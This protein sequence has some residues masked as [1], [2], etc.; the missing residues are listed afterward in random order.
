[1]SS[2][3][4]QELVPGRKMFVHVAEN[5]HTF[6]LDCEAG[7][8]VESV[9]R[10][11]ESLAGLPADDQVLM[12]GAAR[13][14]PRRSL[15][16]YKLP[17]DGNDIFLFNRA[18]L[19]SDCP[20]PA[21]EQI[22]LPEVVV[23]L[24]PLSSHNP[25]PLDEALDPALKA[26]PS[27]ERQFKY[28]FQKGHAIYIANQARFECCKRLLQ[29]QKVQERALETARS[30]MEHTYRNIDQVY[31][32]FMK[33]FSWQ[34][35]QHQ[36]LLAN[37]GRDIER[38]R[39][40]KL[41]PVIRTETRKCL[42]DFTRG[43]N[44]RKLQE[45][46]TISH[47]QFQEKVSQFKG[48]YTELKWSI[49]DLFRVQSPVNVRQVE[50]LIRQHERYLEEQASITQS[51]SKDVN[52]VKKLV[53][54]CVGSQLS[55]SLR[56]HDA[57]SALGPM[58]HVHDRSHLPK[59]EACSRALSKLFEFCKAKK[60]EM[61]MFVHTSM[62]KVSSLQ[63]GI[64]DIRL[65]LSAFNEAMIHQYEIFAEL[66]LV[67]RVGPAY[68]TCLAE[69][70]RR[71]AMMKLYMGQAGQVA[72]KMARIREAE[73]MRREKILHNL[74][75]YIPR[76]VLE[77]LGLFDNPSQCVVNIVPFDTNLIDIDIEDLERF[78]PEAL[79]GPLPKG[80]HSI[81]VKSS[82]SS[83]KSS[84]HSVQGE[85][86]SINASKEYESQMIDEGCDSDE[87]VGT[88]KME[89]EN[90]WLK[91]ELASAIAHICSFDPE[92]VY[93]SVD[94]S[95]V[96]DL[97]QISAQKTAEA[98]RF[99]DDYAKHLK[100]SLK[101]KEIQCS[102]YEKRIQELEQ[103]LDQYMRLQK[104]SDRR[105]SQG[106]ISTV[107]DLKA[108]DCKSED[109]V[110]TGD[111]TAPISS[112]SPEPM[113]E[114]SC[115]S[116]VCTVSLKTERLTGQTGKLLEGVDENMADFPGVMLPET[117]SSASM[118]LD[119]SMMELRREEGQVSAGAN[120][121]T[122]KSATQS[123]STP[124]NNIVPHTL[125]CSMPAFAGQ[126]GGENNSAS[127]EKED[128]LELQKALSEKT[129]QCA[130]IETRLAAVLED[131]ASLR[132]E[133]EVSLK[134]L[135]ESQMNCAHLENCLHEAREESQTNLCAADRRATEYNALRSSSVK[136]RALLERLRN[137]IVAPGAGATGFTESLRSLA[138]SLSSSTI[139]ENEDDGTAEFRACIRVLAE[140]V[141][142]LAQQRVELLD[143][144]TR[145]E[146]AQGHL[147]K[148]LESKTELIKNLYAKHKMERLVNKEKISFTRFEVHE[149][150]AFVRNSA[151]HY[152][153]INRN[154]RNYYL[155]EE[156]IALFV[157][158]LPNGR[159]YIIGQIVHIERNVA[160]QP[161]T[162]S[163]S[164]S[165]YNPYG[166][167]IGVEFFVVTVAMVPDTIQTSHS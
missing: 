151:G 6:E 34:Q 117:V 23:P 102:S 11:L 27:Y 108:D 18:R 136:L 152:E 41:H 162:P 153:A 129:R 49:E 43:D 111:G 19:V 89:V 130:E 62:Q 70:V 73:V 139:D 1:M 20:P 66:K 147:S 65:Q 44:L 29:E 118:P 99:K 163:S 28:H 63:S 115:A 83:S 159:Q 32:E 24:S 78:A 67:R 142:Y 164:R 4:F 22:E 166:L 161:P 33:R 12:C 31:V 84:Y 135:D 125:K 148:E 7:M 40:C 80:D 119:A 9:R 59:M 2:I 93:D 36:D 68:R 10:R 103:R 64:K 116:A 30:T 54:D 39:A 60:H 154:C 50:D 16:E 21:R 71:K 94:E 106:A 98:L 14:D 37:L 52:T 167:P 92:F 13:L 85:E 133:L 114:G 100:N 120:S 132:R 3:D 51:L 48:M 138:L 15:G 95:S 45:T 165:R 107:P 46:C 53:D 91:A 75:A 101:S 88:S 8:S 58:Y 57:V 155:S 47:R 97:L 90:A 158:N 144:C 87:I 131:V 77:A 140:K 127:E 17:S 128:Q 61:T 112:V 72:E 69:V 149:L 157:D 124:A 121:Q 96:E 126:F 113:D 38:L 74:G 5:G 82:F 134:L 79:V 25:H 55:A 81:Q 123:D 42:L 110:A 76:D 146:A 141:V 143:R 26:L 105:D 156:S 150:A 104:L 137:C 145:A 122:V 35:K 160:R 86:G 56:P 109:S